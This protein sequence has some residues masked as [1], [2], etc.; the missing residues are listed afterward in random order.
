MYLICKCNFK[1]APT[2]LS[3]PALPFKFQL[4][5]A[6]MCSFNR[7]ARA[8]TVS[9]E[10][11]LEWMPGT[12]P[13]INPQSIPEILLFHV[14]SIKENQIF[15]RE[16]CTTWQMSRVVLFSAVPGEIRRKVSI[17]WRKASW[18]NYLCVYCW[19]LYVDS[20]SLWK[21]F[22][23]SGTAW[24]LTGF[25]PSWKCAVVVQLEPTKYYKRMRTNFILDFKKLGPWGKSMIQN[26]SGLFVV[27]LLW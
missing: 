7:N 19:I 6:L 8:A 2:W 16:V 1:P 5:I 22:K 17:L 13:H 15:F 9:E 12:D 23:H 25:I 10:L 26:V 24:G 3:I 21:H 11:I 4:D 20:K 14:L 18:N 27:F